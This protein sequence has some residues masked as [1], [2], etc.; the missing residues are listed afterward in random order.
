LL[1][2]LENFLK[3]ILIRE[4]NRNLH[5]YNLEVQ[6]RNGKLLLVDHSFKITRHIQSV[7]DAKLFQGLFSALNEIGEVRMVQFIHSTSLGEVSESMKSC[8]KT[9]Q[10]YGRTPEYIYTDKCCD[11]R[12]YLEES[13]PSIKVGLQQA[14]C[15]PLRI[16]ESSKIQ[17]LSSENAVNA[18]MQPIVRKLESLQPGQ[19]LICGLDCEWVCIPSRQPI[20]L[21]Q[22]AI[23]DECTAKNVF[24]IRCHNMTTL[25]QKLKFVLEHPRLKKAGNY[26]LSSDVRHLSTDY[27]IRIPR[28]DCINLNTFAKT[29]GKITNAQIGLQRLCE[30]ILGYTVPKTDSI[31]TCNWSAP[32]L[33]KAR[34]EYA[35]RDA[36]SSLQIALSLYGLPCIPRHSPA[37]PATSPITP[38]GVTAGSPSPHSAG[39]NLSNIPKQ[40]TAVKLD[41]FHALKRISDDISKNHPALRPAALDLSLAMFSFDLK[42]QNEI[43]SFLQTEDGGSTTFSDVWV[44]NPDWILRRCPRYIPKPADLRNNLLA[45]KRKY[46]HPS[47]THAKFGAIV[48]E[49]SEKALNDLLKHVDKGCL[50]DPEN[51]KLYVPLQKDKF[52]IQIYRCLRGTNTVELWHQFLEMRFSSWNAGIEFAFAA[53]TLLVHRRNIRQ[54]EKYRTNFPKIGHYEHNLIDKIQ[55]IH[56]AVYGR[57]KFE[58]WNSLADHALTKETF[59]V[60]PI[61]PEEKH[62]TFSANDIAHYPASMKFLAEKTKCK[63]P[64]VPVGSKEERLIFMKAAPNYLHNDYIR[65]AEMAEDWNNGTLQLSVQ[66]KRYIL[67]QLSEQSDLIPRGT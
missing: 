25:P 5:Y 54:S 51:I 18:A 8:Y 33:S 50:S 56:Q 39:L 22:L 48:N 65:E 7:G 3:H 38:N 29:K 1:T 34:Q 16:P 49:R 27:G 9:M 12:S 67:S 66:D 32:T 11:D 14:Q 37:T 28:E 31:R 44:N 60:C 42:V 10:T 19:H 35:A 30:I 46:S 13:F 41:A 61:V 36:W 20:A 64:F 63:V 40:L 17:M 23:D 43:D 57:Q 62:D 58:W 45:W 4:V 6:R 15:P 52:G 47:Y 21:I 55:E 59:G 26:I 24:L 53:L 2:I